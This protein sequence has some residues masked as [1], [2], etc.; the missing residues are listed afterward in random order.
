MSVD[1]LNTARAEEIMGQVRRRLR[2]EALFPTQNSAVRWYS[3]PPS[4]WDDGGLHRDQ[5]NSSEELAD[6]LRALYGSLDGSFARSS[7][8]IGEMPPVANTFRGT[9]GR[10]GIG[11]LQ[12]LLWWYTRS[13]KDFAGS[14][15]THLQGSTEAIEVLSSVLRTQQL[16]IASLREEVLILRENQSRDAR[17]CRPENPQ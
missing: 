7:A 14:V 9:V 15:G 17:F 11:I 13:L 8:E 16:E 6:R 12:R 5:A 1:G 4:V 10:F 3:G 2:R